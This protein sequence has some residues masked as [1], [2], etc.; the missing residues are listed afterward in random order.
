[1]RK[2]E[3]LALSEA[4]SMRHARLP[5]SYL[6]REYLMWIR[7]CLDIVVASTAAFGKR[8]R[9]NKTH[10]EWQLRAVNVGEIGWVMGNS[11]WKA[12]VN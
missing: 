1:M 12:S 8:H 3:T 11:A 2:V 4:R 6:V 9:S 7:S 10:H 5:A